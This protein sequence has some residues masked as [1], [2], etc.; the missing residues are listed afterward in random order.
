MAT[1]SEFVG[2]TISRYRILEKLGQGGMGVIY[3]AEDLD[4]GRFVAL[5]FLPEELAQDSQALQRFRREARAASALNHPNIC[6]IY[7]IGNYDGQLFIAMEYLHGM[8][9]KRRVGGRPLENEVLIALAGEIADALNAAHS[10]GV[11]HRDIKSANIFVTENGHAKILDF[12]L[13]KLTLR[14]SNG[15]HE[16]STLTLEEHLTS[17]NAAVGTIAYMSPEQVRAQ[18]LDTRTD[19]FSFGVVLYEMATG[20]LPFRG[21]S[22]G[23]IFKAI[24]DG[25]PS[26]AIRLNPDLPAELE[27]IMTKCLEKEPRLRYQHASEIRTDLER[28]KRHNANRETD[29]KATRSRTPTRASLY[30]WT[31]ASVAL[32]VAATLLVRPFL[33]STANAASIHSIAVLPF[34]NANKD[35]NM[36]YLG[37]GLSEEITNSLSRLPNLQVMAHSTVW[38]YRLQQ[39]DPRAVGRELHVDAVLTGR[40]VE[41]GNQLVVE[42]ELVNVAAGTQFWGERYTRKLTDASLLQP[43]I[44]LDLASQLR[45]QLS[46]N[47]RENL[48]TAGT[49]NAEAYNDYLKGR[50]QFD[51]VEQ[52]E[53]MRAAANLFARAIALDSNYAAAYAGLADA[54]AEEGYMG[55][56]PIQDSFDRSRRSAL[57]ALELD[58]QIPE[59][60]ISLALGDLIYS[61]NFAEAE[62]AMQTALNLDPNSAWAHEVSCW[63]N[64]DLGRLQ[65]A[66]AECSRALELDPLSL[67]KDFQLATA[68]YYARD[69]K[70]AIE[71]ANDTLRLDPKYAPAL[72]TL[73]DAYEMTGNYKQ[74]VQQWSKAARLVGNE[75]QGKELERTF[76]QGGHVGYLLDDAKHNERDGDYFSAAGDYAMLGKKNAAFKALEKA[77]SAHN[78]IQL[79]KAEP[80]FDSIRSDPRYADLLRRIGLPL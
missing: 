64:E 77:Y 76:D 34:A 72:G 73:G 32:C 54:Y 37:E 66:I 4:L 24:L 60:H 12:G 16:E 79:I 42:T 71:R 41:N 23:V 52:L 19:L 40:V 11:V 70:S 27:G 18:E 75:V 8:T 57:R 3:K 33:R 67:L 29:A 43:A 44:I 7:E 63:L 6:T 46:G 69:Y 50:Y 1:P 59:S 68:Y 26:P 36:D 10:K 14:L 17:P 28:L 2:Q 80:A 62:K 20:T 31:M 51:K 61:W 47:A 58:P 78:R 21:E 65:I 22:S 45:P 48:G 15:G 53:D 55:S 74:A 49:K 9:L 39:D 13:A 5:K 25:T 35:P 56:A 30:L 38:H